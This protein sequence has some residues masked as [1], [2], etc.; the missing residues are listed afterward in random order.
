MQKKLLKIT[1]LILL[2]IIPTFLIWLPFFARVKSFWT[3][4]LPQQGMATIVSNFDGPLYL[5]IAKTFYN[6]DLIGA[7]YQFPLSNEYY[8]AHFPLFPI[9]IKTFAIF[10]GHPY[11]MLFVTLISSFLAL[12]FF[13]KHARKFLDKNNAMWLTFVFA[14]FPARWLIVRSVGSPEPFFI[15]A[16]LAS[17]YFF[18]KKK[19]IWAGIWGALA[20]MTKSPGILLFLAYLIQISIPHF[21]ELATG[22]IKKFILKL[23]LK[24]TYPIFFIPL[25]LLVVFTIYGF[26]Y[27]D[28]FTYFKSGDNIHLFFPPFQ[29]FNF[30]APWVGTFWLEEIIFVYTI[31]VLGVYKLYEEKL[32]NYFYFSLIFFISLLFVAHRDLLRYAL[33]LISFLI[34]AFRETLIKR[35]FKI[36]MV[37]IIIPIYLYSLAFISQNAMPIANWAP[38]L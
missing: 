29:I 8:S 2:T 11:S 26:T 24:N 10:L 33:P 14:I 32:F 16:I 35:E 22:G 7:N 31:G 9:L 4:P 1:I 20:Q 13:N 21:K 12:F 23:D 30:S 19:Y 34:L 25:G 28:F 17:T 36:A 37:V 27:G 38:F 18:G 5:I 15:A 6:P 3:I